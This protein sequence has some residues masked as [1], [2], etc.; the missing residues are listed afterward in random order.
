M[1][2]MC[3]IALFIERMTYMG[4]DNRSER[5]CNCGGDE[6]ESLIFGADRQ[7]GKSS[8][9]CSRCGLSEASAYR[10]RSERR[11][12]CECSSNDEQS[13]CSLPMLGA[14]TPLAA[15]YA[16]D[17]RFDD[18]YE[19]DEAIEHGT[20]FIGLYKPFMGKSVA[21]GCRR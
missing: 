2:L 15:V 3:E 20:L 19:I 9:S 16:P 18:I 11:N 21:G 1:Q 8:R 7:K 17:H 12:S 14:E 10:A 4:I 13:N 6:L 5:P